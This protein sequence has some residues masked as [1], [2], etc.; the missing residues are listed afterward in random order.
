MN[1]DDLANPIWL[2][3]SLENRFG[4]C[5]NHIFDVY[6]KFYMRNPWNIRKQPVNRQTH[7]KVIISSFVSTFTCAVC[8]CTVQSNSIQTGTNRT[9]R[10]HIIRVYCIRFQLKCLEQLL[11]NILLKWIE[12]E[13]SAATVALTARVNRDNRQHL[14]YTSF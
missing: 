3:L 1:V 8:M 6:S 9:P 13:V 5:P 7:K 4:M 14:Y 12:A 10:V 2:L 11:P